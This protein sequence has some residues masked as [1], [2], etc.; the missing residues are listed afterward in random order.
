MRSGIYQV[1]FSSPTTRVSGEGLAVVKDGTIN[2]GDL[3]YL[4]T[5]KFNVSDTTLSSKLKVKQWRPNFSGVFGNLPQFELDLAGRIAEDWQSFS[6]KGG[7]VGNP[8]TTILID[9]KRLADAA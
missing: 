8:Q 2:G 7:I 9:G 5:G 4:Y 1:T 6:V 3:G